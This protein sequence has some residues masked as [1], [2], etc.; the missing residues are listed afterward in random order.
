MVTIVIAVILLV[1]GLALVFFQ[2]ESIDLIKGIGLPG[3]IQRQIV[4]LMEEK[5][6]AWGLL[7][8]SPI[9]L[10]LGSLLRGI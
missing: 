2:T 10:I 9:L 5:T 7:A 8:A 6:L 1:L 4:S 3:D